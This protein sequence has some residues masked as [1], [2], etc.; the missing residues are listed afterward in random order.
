MSTNAT[1]SDLMAWLRLARVSALPSAISN[2]LAGFLVAQRSW[3]PSIELAI[4]IGSSC[5]LYMSGM[6]LNDVFDVA[7]DSMERPQRPIPSG[8][9]SRKSAAIVG[10][11]LLLLGVGLAVSL[12]WRVS[13]ATTWGRWRPAGVAFALA[14]CVIL[15]DGVL[16]NTIIAPLLMGACRMLNVFLGA[17]TVVPVDGPGVAS[18][19]F[20]LIVIWV[21]VSMG[22]FTAGV[23]LLARK[24]SS[25][26]QNRNA[27]MVAGV[28]ILLGLAGWA[29][30]TLCPNHQLVANQNLLTMY[31]LLIGLI[32]LPILRRVIAAI[33]TGAPKSIQ[34]AVV[35]CLK[36]IIILD[37]ALCFLIAP[38]Q[39]FYALVVIGLLI[40]SMLLSRVVSST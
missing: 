13:D 26:N 27:L 37:A 6:I 16:K 9:I 34:Q 4:L 20:P 23:T 10:A 31:P 40:P 2:I 12:G 30:V 22:T 39:I 3:S 14:V 32:S 7:A 33:G 15:Y 1:S 17:S 18:L 29:F 36:S 38:D 21:A 25:V 5:C 35:T 24:E 11:I 8:Q 19:G 28:M